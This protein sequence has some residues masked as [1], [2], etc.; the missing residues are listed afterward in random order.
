[1]RSAANLWLAPLA[2]LLRR[3]GR[4]VREALPRLPE[5][6]GPREGFCPGAGPRLQ[7]LVLG[8]STVAG[9]GVRHMAESLP[10]RLGEAVARR[11]DCG[12]EWHAFGRT[13]HT[14][15]ENDALLQLVEDRSQELEDADLAVICLGVSDTIAL[16]SPRRFFEKIDCLSIRL[17]LLLWPLPVLLAGVPQLDRFPARLPHPLRG[18]LGLRS[19]SLDQALAKC[20]RTQ[21][22]VFH[23][24]GQLP[25][26]VGDQPGV[27]A[28]DGFH[29]G[30]EG[31]RLWAEHLAVGVETMLAQTRGHRN[32]NRERSVLDI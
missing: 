6:P 31:C 24:P 7:M 22:Q 5:A 20:A 30:P 15:A 1:M 10:A 17:R 28:A 32:D 2:P 4:A 12:V 18:V 9:V 29:P 11:L 14:V 8:E 13:G 23:H 16:T 21:Y 3:Q 26:T 27:F 19:Q 25:P